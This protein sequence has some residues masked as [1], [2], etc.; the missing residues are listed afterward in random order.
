V[1]RR[2]AGAAG[3]LLSRYRTIPDLVLGD[4]RERILDGRLAPG[5]RIPLR[6]VAT[7][8]GVSTMPVREALTKLEAEG[9]VVSVPH[10]G[11]IVV[12]LS[13]DLIREIYVVRIAL[14]TTAARLAAPNLD[15]GALDVVARCLG[16]MK[17]G[18]EAGDGMVLQEQNKLF[19][20][21]IYAASGNATLQELIQSQWQATEHY[22]RRMYA[23]EPGWAS[24]AYDD[25]VRIFDACRNH[26]GAALE[27]LTRAHLEHTAEALCARV[28]ATKTAGR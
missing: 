9:L 19:H 10:R 27:S 28:E 12:R 25:H 2:G 14:E 5:E 3:L 20:S 18:L 6:Q 24:W 11:A 17:G 15:R 16:A 1:D 7:E 21:T 8:M 22:R 4:L 26:D 13:P 23:S